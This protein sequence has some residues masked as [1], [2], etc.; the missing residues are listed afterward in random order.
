MRN[1]DDAIVDAIEE[2]LIDRPRA[3]CAGRD[4][5]PQDRRYRETTVAR[6]ETLALITRRMQEQPIGA[7]LL[8]VY[9]VLNGNARRP[10]RAVNARARSRGRNRILSSPGW[11][12]PKSRARFV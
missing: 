9:R 12:C 1:E 10:A 6:R 7:R 4:L 11:N 8:S 2:T 3:Q 5:A